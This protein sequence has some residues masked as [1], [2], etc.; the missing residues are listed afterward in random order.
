MKLYKFTIV[1]VLLPLLGTVLL[2]GCSKTILVSYPSQL[3]PVRKDL[4]DSK[5]AAAEKQITDESN[6]QDAVLYN[7]ELA[8]V[9]QIAGQ[10]KASLATYRKAIQ[11]VEKQ[12]LAAKVQGSRVLATAASMFT[13]DNAIP[14][15]MPGFEQVF[16]YQYQALNYYSLDDAVNALVSIRKADNQQRFVKQQHY[17]EVVA[18]QKVA[19]KKKYDYNPKTFAKYFAQTQ[20]AAGKI[21]SS[22]ENAFTYY[23]SSVAFEANHDYNNAWVSIQNALGVQPNNDTIRR[24]LLEV[25]SQRGAST[26]QMLRYKLK[27]GYLTTPKIP[28]NQG[29]LVVVYEQG[30]V[31]P[32]Q[33]LTIPIP[34]IF[35]D[36]NQVQK[37]AIPIYRKDKRPIPNLAVDL[38]KLKMGTTSVVV[39]TEEM[40]AKALLE[41]YPLI[42]TRTV[43]R[44]IAKTAATHEANKKDELA[45]LIIQI[46]SNITTQ[47]DLRSWLT[48]PRTIQIWQGYL[49]TGKNHLSLS[50]GGLKRPVT[51]SIAAGQTTVLWVIQIGH[52]WRVNVMQL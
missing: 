41:E 26:E 52:M 27:F 39:N 43:L 33:S 51:A 14:Y 9:Q 18:A 40:A 6:S 23:L 47:A 1:K 24:Q 2:A 5:Y 13:N 17:Q 28:K 32:R 22:F 35:G 38:Q 15:L 34:I 49:P 36:L 4:S 3:A 31:P 21:K 19:K 30:L 20:G 50:T 48:L 42:I 11:E 37:V 46:L 10:Y 29:K 45:G 25:L 12:N 8:R 44:L 16:L 7:A